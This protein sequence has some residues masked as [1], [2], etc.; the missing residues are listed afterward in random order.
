MDVVLP[1]CFEFDSSLF[2][3]PV[4]KSMH[5]IELLFLY[6]AYALKTSYCD[7]LLCMKP[8]S[9]KY[10]GIQKPDYR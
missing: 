7:S 9:E 8:D 3:M 5:I 6:A 10:V 1:P 2:V 4:F